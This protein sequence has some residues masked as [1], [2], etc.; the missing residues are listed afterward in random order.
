[1]PRMPRSTRAKAVALARP[2]P[3]LEW[4]AAALAAALLVAALL[5]R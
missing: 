5:A 1:M 2:V 4:L 3:A